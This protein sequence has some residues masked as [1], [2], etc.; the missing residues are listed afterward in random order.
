MKRHAL[1]IL[2]CVILCLASLEV[3]AAPIEV[4]DPIQFQPGIRGA[5]ELTFQTAINVYYQVELSED[6]T[7]WDNEGY[8]VKGTG[9]QVTVMASTRNLATVFYRLRDDGDPNNTAPVGPQGEQGPEGPVGPQGEPGP[10]GPIG[11][12]GIQGPQ[13]EAGPQGPQGNPGPEGAAGIDASAPPG[14]I[15]AYAGSV[16]DSGGLVEPVAGYLLCNGAVINANTNN[17]KYASL[18][19][20]IG[21]SWGN[22]GNASDPDIVNLPDLRGVLLRGWNGA[23]SDSYADSNRNTR[24]ARKSG[25]NTGNNIGSFQ[26]E[27]YRN[28]AAPYS[29]NA[30]VVY[31][32]KY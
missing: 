10:Q 19:A 7:E 3:N 5:V 2:S 13:G 29:G 17:G 18:R 23:A 27:D 14:T 6:L 28:T 4:G 20:A 9:G 1:S 12:Q 31:L 11:P 26:L 21:N 30:Y 25:G 16:T 8:S 15:I 24:V 22:G 32:I